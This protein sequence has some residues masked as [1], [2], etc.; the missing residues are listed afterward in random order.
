MCEMTADEARYKGIYKNFYYPNKLRTVLA[1]I[2]QDKRVY[3]LPINKIYAILCSCKWL[4]SIEE[5]KKKKYKKFYYPTLKAIAEN[6]EYQ[7]NTYQIKKK[8][9]NAL[10][11]EFD[12]EKE[13][14]EPMET[15]WDETNMDYVNQQLLNKYQFD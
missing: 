5:G 7:A 6:P 1:Q 15:P 10:Y 4:D 11:L 13:Q 8:L 3:E 9:S 2:A 14:E 12:Q